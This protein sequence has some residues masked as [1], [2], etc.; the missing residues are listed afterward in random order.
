VVSQS[1]RKR[2]RRSQWF[3]RASGEMKTKMNNC[4]VRSGDGFEHILLRA[5]ITSARLLAVEHYWFRRLFG[6]EYR[7]DE[8][9]RTQLQHWRRYRVP[10]VC[11]RHCEQGLG[12]VKSGISL[13][14]GSGRRGG[15]TA[16]GVLCVAIILGCSGSSGGGTGNEVGGN[17]GIG[18]DSAGGVVNAGGRVATGGAKAQG[19][20][21]SAGGALITGGV[22]S[23][24]GN[25]A[26]VSTGGSTATGGTSTTGGITATGGT[27]ATGGALASGGTKAG[28]GT[29]T[30]G[31][32]Q[33]SGGALNT[34]GSKSAG[35]T[36]STG[37]T[38]TTG[39]NSS[40]GGAT[41]TGGATSR[42]GSGGILG[43]GGTA[44]TAGS[45][46]IDPCAKVCPNCKSLFDGTSL[47]GWTQVPASSWSV[48]NGA[49]HSLGPARGFI[50]TTNT[51]GDFR[52]IFTSR[53]ISDP[54][55]HLPCVLFW[56]N[57][58]TKDALSAIQIQPP[59]GYMWDYRTTGPT[60]NQSPD[61]YETRFS[62]PAMVDTQWSQCEM[63]ANQAAGT[64][65]FACCQITGTT[66]CKASEVVDFKDPT[67]GLKAPLALQVHN[68]NMIE[69]F[70]DLCIE[71][72][73][74]DPSTLVTTQ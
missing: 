55:N 37:G 24:G 74:A 20:A 22:G 36:A 48:V 6:S 2:C 15:L 45:G 30:T 26:T 73:V 23:T 39:G 14:C 47:S 46:A 68:A 70:K 31:G 63:L 5:F 49:M 65:R 56:G 1:N 58:P 10:A 52:F 64:M 71:S 50:Y 7:I 62:H 67:A 3:D 25:G 33:P 12:V 13:F 59:N 66:P 54:A 4:D 11:I 40:T 21:N 61:R 43:S 18:G 69:E 72:P 27:L 44:G 38:K 17:A 8:V 16:L 19:G 57:S 9:R 34:G 32:S 60:S 35:G 41:I 28:G 29:S 42:G 53:L 51:Y